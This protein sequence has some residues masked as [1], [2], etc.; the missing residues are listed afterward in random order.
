M[1]EA[2]KSPAAVRVVWRGPSARASQA[3]QVSLSR[4]AGPL[5][6]CL[7][8]ALAL[9]CGE[10]PL[11]SEEN[12]LRRE[13]L[14]QSLQEQLGSAYDEPVDTF[15]G[16]PARGEELYDRLCVSC[17][18]RMGDGRGSV[19]R[20][21]S[22]PP[23]SFTDPLQSSFLSDQARLEILRNGSPGTTMR[24][25]ADTLSEQE[26]AELFEQVRGFASEVGLGHAAPMD[27]DLGEAGP[28]HLFRGMEV[29][30]APVADDFAL[31]DQRGQSF[32]LADQRGRV[33]LLYF[34]YIHCPDM[35]PATLSIWTDLKEQLGD[36]A[37]KVSFVFV[38]VD[39]SRDTPERLQGLLSVFGDHIIGLT[40]SRAELDPVYEAFDVHREQVPVGESAEAYLMDHGLDTLLIDRR[41]R[42]RVRFRFGTAAEDMVDDVRWLL[43]W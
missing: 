39:P 36:D 22:V 34:G 16:D 41:G 4:R 21:L 24:G 11:S 42:P 19:A 20:H 23:G 26:L 14:R 27:R 40:G 7:L 5:V 37:A 12:D 28:A 25:F 31:T 3:G 30:D 32:S 1:S 17:H 2:M 15:V 8:V 29:F 10:P 13:E 18:G 43:R 9:G 35:C 38:T 33:V 6:S